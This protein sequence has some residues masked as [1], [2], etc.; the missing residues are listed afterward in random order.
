[1]FTYAVA[2]TIL[3]HLHAAEGDAQRAA[4]RG[5]LKHLKR[6]GIP[7]GINPGRGKKIWYRYE[8]LFEWA[9]CLE[10]AEFGIDPTVAVR[11]VNEHWERD[12]LPRIFD[13]QEETM[14][15]SDVYFALYPKFMTRA[16]E[17]AD[18]PAFVFRWLRESDKLGRSEVSRWMRR[19][20][21]AMLMN[22]SDLVRTIELLGTRLNSQRI[23]NRL[24]T[25]FGKV[26]KR[27]RST[28]E[29]RQ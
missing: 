27:K 17:D 16:W 1:M 3:A 12:I 24:T 20:R 5:R 10:L 26:K 15:K 11:L 2:E 9:F 18:T 21:R 29:R 13:I 28:T 8:Q 19:Q 6:L 14:Q 22:M 4:F 25:E 7:R 23:H